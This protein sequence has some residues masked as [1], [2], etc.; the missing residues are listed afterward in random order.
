MLAF[1]NAEISLYKISLSKSPAFL[2]I[3]NRDFDRIQT[4]HSC[5]QAVKSFFDIYLNL[6]ISK[7]HCLSVPIL[8]YFTWSLGVLQLLTTFEHPDWNLEWARSAISFTDVLGKLS[9]IYGQVKSTLNL[10]PHTPV[11]EDIFSHSARR[12][13]WM[14][15]FF[16]S[17]GIDPR[18]DHNPQYSN[19]ENTTD[20]SLGNDSN[21]LDDQWL[22]DLMELW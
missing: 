21:L 1:K 4:L 17:G 22:R 15:S 12:M 9:D 18:L 3:S 5:L 10:D 8:T 11:G 14:K 13:S 7:M 2:D 20:L 6:P 19:S 16:E